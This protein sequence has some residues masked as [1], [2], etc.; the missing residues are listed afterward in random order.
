M[1]R[2]PKHDCLFEPIRIGPKTMKNRFFQVPH[3]TGAGSE[4][5]GT[6]M[7]HRAV[8]AEGGWGAI[9]TE[10]AA[11]HPETDTEPASLVRLWDEGDRMNL[12]PMVEACHRYGALA[13]VELWDSGPETANLET[14][15]VAQGVGEWP[16]EVA[17]QTYAH[18]A[19]EDD[20]RAFIGRYAEAAKL[21][22][23]AGFDLVYVYGSHRAIPIQFLS[24]RTNKRTDKYGGSFENRARFWIEALAALKESVGADMAVVAR[25]CVDQLLGPG[26]IEVHE[27]GLRFVELAEREGV[28]DLWDVNISRYMEWGEDAGPSRFYKANHQGPWVKHVKGVAKKPVLC[29]GRFTSPNDMV[30]VIKSGQA[31]IIGAARPSIADPYLPKKIEEGRPEDIRECIGCN[32]CISRWELGSR[33]VC[34][35]NATANEE[36]RRGWHPEKF[37]RTKE[38]CAVLVVGGGPSGMEC[39]RVLA[40]RGYDVHLVEAEKELGGHVRMVMRYPGLA[41]WGRVVSYRTTQLA[42]LKTVEVHTGTRLNA[43]A[44]LAYGADKIVLAAGSHWALDGMNNINWG[45]LPGADANRPQFATPEQVM[46]G[47]PIGE[48]VVVLDADGYFTGIGMAETMA[49]LGKEVTIVTQYATV[50]PMTEY[51]LEKANVQRMLRAKNIRRIMDSWV[52]RIEA[53]NVVK[54]LVYDNWRDGYKRASGPETGKAPIERGQAAQTIEC[55]SVILV[56]ARRPNDALYKALK[57]R[58]GQWAAQGIRGIYQAGDCYAPRLLAQAIFDGHRIAREFESPDPQRPLPF[59][60]ERL[61]W[62]QSMLP[63]LPR[64]ACP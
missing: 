35:Q 48:R 16:G 37:E 44:V 6:Q 43:E 59:I 19:D 56:T 61:L 51:T 24:P 47:K 50:A 25:L 12:V 5:P 63:S 40:L 45:A 2:D 41:E 7:G 57:E 14:R 53:G 4:R 15:A 55:D 23:G 34:T 29:V 28:V 58:R 8:K 36:F 10:A 31:D 39:A 52:E 33:M 11:I 9:C 30:E 27:D 60:R 21:A 17:M 49:D 46:G 54:V 1:P 38:P 62:G 32:I 13:G 18:Y 22:H 64:T 20:I 3:C 42:K 26:G